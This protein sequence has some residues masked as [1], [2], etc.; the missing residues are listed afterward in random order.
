MH[1]NYDVTILI[2]KII[3][4][5]EI[6]LYQRSSKSKI[7]KTSWTVEDEATPPKDWKNLKSKKAPKEP[8]EKFEVIDKKLIKFKK[9]KKGTPRCRKEIE[10]DGTSAH[11]NR[12]NGCT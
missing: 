3:S 6:L 9:K 11:R 5:K 8:I 7:K 1:R 4:E 12:Q 10:A 2:V